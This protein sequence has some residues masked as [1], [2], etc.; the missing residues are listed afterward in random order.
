[1]LRRMLDP[2][3]LTLPPSSSSSSSSPLSPVSVLVSRDQRQGKGYRPL[4]SRPTSS[5]LEERLKLHQ[6]KR[7]REEEREGEER[8]EE[9]REKEEEED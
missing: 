7:R 8:E 2:L 9:E 5:S 6:S 3:S 4:L 1:M